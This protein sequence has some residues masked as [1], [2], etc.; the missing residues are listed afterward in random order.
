VYGEISQINGARKILECLCLVSKDISSGVMYFG[1]PSRP[2][3]SA[4]MVEIDHASVYAGDDSSGTTHTFFPF[5]K[6]IIYINKIT[7]KKTLK[8]P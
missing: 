6:V 2:F 7:Y 3:A 1:R 5:I 8:G 4:Q